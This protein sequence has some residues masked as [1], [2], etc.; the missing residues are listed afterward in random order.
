ME[1]ELT[2]LE[3]TVARVV[4]LSRQLRESESRESVLREEVD[5]LQKRIATL[6]AQKREPQC[7]DELIHMGEK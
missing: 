4:V 3:R 6:L 5:Y 2:D 1:S 7:L